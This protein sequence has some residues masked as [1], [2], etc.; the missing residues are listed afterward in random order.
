MWSTKLFAFCCLLVGASAC[1]TEDAADE[2]SGSDAVKKGS[3]TAKLTNKSYCRN[4]RSLGGGISETCLHFKENSTG[5]ETGVSG[6]IPR[7]EKFSYSVSGKKVTVIISSPLSAYIRDLTLADDGS[8]MSMKEGANVFVW[9][10][11]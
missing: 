3:A 4:V 9:T 5:E 8:T 1:A 10:R 7:N 2:A 6:G 11:K